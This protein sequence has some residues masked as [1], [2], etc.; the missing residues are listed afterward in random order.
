MIVGGGQTYTTCSWQLAAMGQQLWLATVGVPARCLD[1]AD[2]AVTSVTLCCDQLGMLAADNMHAPLR[3][4]RL[5]AGCPGSPGWLVLQ[6]GQLAMLATV[7]V[8]V[9]LS[10]ACHAWGS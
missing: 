4:S 8:S 6:R 2:F 3:T 5:Q 7:G 9:L 1:M 10:T